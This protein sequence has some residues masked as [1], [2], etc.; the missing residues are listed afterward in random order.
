[1]QQRRCGT[2]AELLAQSV[3]RFPNDTA[4][5]APDRPPLTYAGLGVQ[6]EAAARALAEAG[7]GRG[8]RI[9]VALPEGPEF[10]AAMLSVCAVS[11]CAPL[12]HGLDE[13]ALA[14]L[15]AAMRIDVLM[16]ADGTRPA[17]VHAARRAAVPLLHLCFS[18]SAPAGTFELVAGQR[19]RPIAPAEVV[20]DDIALVTH[21]SGTTS[22]PKIV[23]IE[24]WRMVEAAHS[25]AALAQ[26]RGTDRSLLLT[27]LYSIA[28][29][30]RGLLA[31]LTVGGAVVCP[32]AVDGGSVVDVLDTLAPTLYSAPP[33]VQSAV[34]EEFERRSPRPHHSLRLIF[35]SQA[36]LRAPLQRRLEQAFGVPVIRAYGMTE[37][38][39]IAQAPLPPAHAPAG[40]VG[41]PHNLEVAIADD[42]GRLL[43]AGE[44]GEILVRGPEVF[45]GYENDDEANR[46]A[47]RDG[48]FRT[49][50]CGHVDQDGF[51]FLS[52]R[53]KDLINRGG[54]KIAPREVEEA[55]ERHPGVVEAAAFAL[56]HPTLG[57]A[58]AAAVVVR[59]PEQVT[60]GELRRYARSR[61]AAFKV[62]T[63]VVLVGQL[64]RGAFGKVDRRKLAEMAQ[65]PASPSG[66]PY[67]DEVEA[68]L[69]GVFAE[70][71]GVAE[72]GREDSFFDLGGDSLRGV[73]VLVRVEQA[74]SVSV[75]LD[76]LI[77]HPSLAEFAAAIRDLISR[78]TQFQ[79]GAAPTAP[80]SAAPAPM[81]RQSDEA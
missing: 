62:P 10:A 41:R 36:E 30:Y 39:N 8:S 51:V 25:R 74:F 67:A 11:T 43:A 76:L 7:Y 45:G 4:I 15:L 38:G 73:R 14:G 49:G 27:P 75:A 17:A 58:V 64:P 53:I 12:N 46:A 5:V 16:V 13:A 22:A 68:K 55:L 31:P 29:V 33:A 66:Q 65:G 9:A 50:D 52:G 19:R 37:T 80:V 18:P 71:L 72:V 32:T 35:S 24:Q 20:P 57:E 70:V 28:G 23:P 47:F 63:R 77:D 56:P 69:A 6:L 40:S 34:V 59:D 3:A 79:P 42:S 60:G 78:P 48:W 61:L 2:L 1:M 21:T 54:A 26:L 44:E 81:Q